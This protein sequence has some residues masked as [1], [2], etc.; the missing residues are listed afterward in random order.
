M[1]KANQVVKV[2][3]MQ[4]NIATAID[5][6]SVCLPVFEKYTKLLEQIEQKK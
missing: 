5:S 2:R 3:R 1:D 4:K 6:V